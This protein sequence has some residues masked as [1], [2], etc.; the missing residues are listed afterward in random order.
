MTN[1]EQKDQISKNSNK[2]IIPVML[3]GAIVGA[4]M[5]LAGSLILKNE[6]SRTKLKDVLKVSS[7]LAIKRL[8]EI[9]MESN[10]KKNKNKRL[11]VT[12]DSI[13]KS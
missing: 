5:A 3:G 2:T 11:I 12:D 8:V 4:G 6:K 10:S 1:I 7:K 13:K 9:R